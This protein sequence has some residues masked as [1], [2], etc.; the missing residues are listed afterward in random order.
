MRNKDIES[1][2][3]ALRAKLEDTPTINIEWKPLIITCFQSRQ[4]GAFGRFVDVASPS[5]DRCEFICVSESQTF[6]YPHPEEAYREQSFVFTPKDTVEKGKYFLE[7]QINLWRKE[8]YIKVVLGT[9]DLYQ[10]TKSKS[11]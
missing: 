2:A 10:E 9:Y 3:E 6:H 4:G 11:N 8:D 1:K 5:F 7:N